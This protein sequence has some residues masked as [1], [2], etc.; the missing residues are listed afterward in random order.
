VPSASR[1]QNTGTTTNG[2]TTNG[3]TNNGTTTNNGN[4]TTTNVQGQGGILIDADGV[5]RRRLTKSDAARLNRG[6]IAVARGEKNQDISQLRK[7]SINRLEQAVKSNLE[8]G[9]P[10]DEEMLF[11][12][13]LSELQYVF[14]YPDSGDIVLAGPAEPWGEVIEG[15]MCGRTTGRPVFHLEDLI[16][17]LR[18][19]G[20]KAGSQSPIVSC[21]IDPTPDGL[22]KMQSFLRQLGSHAT[23]GDTQFIVDG[24][25]TSLGMQDV[26]FTG[27]PARTHFALTL[28]EADYRMKLIG[29]GLERPP[30]RLT[31]YVAVANPTSVSRNA[32]QRWWFVPDYECVRV[33]EDGMALELEGDGVMLVGE[34]EV[35]SHDG[36]RRTT[37][38]QSRASKVFVTN[39]SKSYPQLADA[40]PVY[41]HLRNLIDLSISVAFMRQQGWFETSGWRMDAFSDEAVLPVETYNTPKQVETAVASVWKRN[42]LM[43]PVGGGVRIEPDEALK[44]ERRREDDSG[45]LHGFRQGL[46]LSHLADGQWWW[47]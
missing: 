11:L 45:R 14:Y 46:E 27:V 5:L 29:I 24:L 10:L 41:A 6:R 47:D 28:V 23:P 32:M 35:V 4:T 12:A 17:A 20:P 37:G 42:T 1:A 33:S 36:S 9:Q 21:S 19:Y 18:T 38:E 3:T 34:D 8:A 22:S 43:T 25:R 30:V 40:V 31:S 26:S 39:F 13:G 15:R 2:T 16:V 7:V 44:T